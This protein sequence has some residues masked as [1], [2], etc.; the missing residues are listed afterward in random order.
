[1]IEIQKN[2]FIT[3]AFFLI[4]VIQIL[5]SCSSDDAHKKVIECYEAYNKAIINGDGEE[6]IKYLDSRT[7]D[8]YAMLL[9]KALY[10]EKETL[11]RESFLNRLM[12]VQIRHMIPLE[13]VKNMNAK[14]LLIYAIN[15]EWI[16]K[17]H[18]VGVKVRNVRIEE[19]FAVADSYKDNIK[20]NKLS[21][22]YEKEQWRFN[23]TSLVTIIG[24]VFKKQI[25]ETGLSENEF[26]LFAVEALSGKSVSEDVYIPLMNR[27]EK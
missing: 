12:I 6:A 24:P 4:F 26:I 3:K 17:E 5:L 14:A 18:V 1:M 7:I 21:F 13:K 11:L 23:L 10:A 27:N 2:I 25:K 9:K 16:G 8:Y 20:M 22:Y 15:N 19:N